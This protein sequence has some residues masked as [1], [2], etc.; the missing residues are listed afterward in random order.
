[1][2]VKGLAAVVTGGA[3]GLG[4]AT[5]EAL[6]A[7]GAKVTILDVQEEKLRATAAEIGAVPAICD[8]TSAESVQAALAVARD[9]NGAVRI[10]VNCAG[11]V[12]GGRIVGKNGPMD[13]AG[14]ARTIQINLVGTFNVM[15]QC[16]AEMM[17]QDVLNEDNERGL[18][19]NTASIAAFDGQIGQAAYSAS[20]GGVASLSLP[21]ARE[22]APKGIRVMCIAP[23]LF[24]TP[25]MTGL[26]PDVYDSLIAKT[27]FPGRLGKASEY[28]RMVVQIAAN[29][30]L[31]GECIRLDGALR[32]EPR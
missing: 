24:E 9:A 30:M 20:K 18:V 4:R 2:D 10:N 32:L 13:L 8:V 1:M 17:T 19:V 12:H 21:A 23:G 14:F 27:L 16:A 15:S 6:I 11:V 5:A 25:M 7:A 29:P 26:P 28:G 22:F 31:N 3:S